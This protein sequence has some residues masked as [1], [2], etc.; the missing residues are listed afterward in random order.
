MIDGLL[1]IKEKVSNDSISFSHIKES[2][3]HIIETLK[4]SDK[5]NFIELQQIQTFD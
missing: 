2:K 4:T 1:K 3:S 5:T